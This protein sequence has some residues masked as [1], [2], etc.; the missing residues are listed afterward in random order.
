M[1]FFSLSGNR[2]GSI[3]PSNRRDSNLSGSSPAA[4]ASGGGGSQSPANHN[5]SN[6]TSAAAAGGAMPPT[7]SAAMGGALSG[8]NAVKSVG[9]A[10]TYHSSA[11]VKQEIV[12]NVLGSTIWEDFFKS[13]AFL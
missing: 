4:N 5:N 3:V 13:E 2:M 8:G 12:N 7:S 1:R 6:N 11:N 10:S 9:S